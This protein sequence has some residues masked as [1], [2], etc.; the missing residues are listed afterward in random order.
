MKS[1]ITDFNSI[2]QY[3]SV[4]KKKTLSNILLCF[5][6][7]ISI[8][9]FLYTSVLLCFFLVGIDNFFIM[10]INSYT[11]CWGARIGTRGLSTN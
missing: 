10:M 11:Y 4:K 9:F 7:S 3:S 1:V 2:I 8:L 5:T 6:V